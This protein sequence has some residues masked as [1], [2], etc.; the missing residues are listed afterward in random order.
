MSDIS[1]PSLYQ[2]VGPTGPTGATAPSIYAQQGKC[3]NHAAFS[4]LKTIKHP[5]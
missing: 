4:T 5:L 1:G 3:R 2:D